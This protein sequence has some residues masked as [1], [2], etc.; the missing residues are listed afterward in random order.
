MIE[1]IHIYDIDGTLISS[2][3]RY[4]TAECGTRIDLEYWREHDNDRS[5][6]KD[7]PLPHLA[8]YKQDLKNPKIYV[9]LATARVCYKGDAN[10]KYIQRRM[11]IPDKFV[12]RE[13]LEDKRGG[14]EL[15]I[16]AIKPLL[17]LKQFKNAA[18]HIWEDNKDYLSDMVCALNGI[19]HYIPST[20]GH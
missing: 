11:G 10:Y 20:Q 12:H 17:N 16:Q 6:Y 1:K 9:I 7:S 19:G 18:V 2:S 5:I 13:G 14:A 3:H 4:R 15:K 8:Q